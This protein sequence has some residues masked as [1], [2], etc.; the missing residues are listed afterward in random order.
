MT[1]EQAI[2][3]RET[4]RAML[5]AREDEYRTFYATV[6]SKAQTEKDLRD[7]KIQREIIDMRVSAHH[8]ELRLLDEIIEYRKP[9]EEPVEEPTAGVVE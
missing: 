1:Y 2:A 7:A 6:L 5:E 4:V 8:T 3:K 9:P